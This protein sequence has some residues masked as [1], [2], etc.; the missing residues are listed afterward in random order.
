[1]KTPK[2]RRFERVQLAVSQRPFKRAVLNK[3]FQHFCDTGELPE[4]DDRLAQALLSRAL[5]GGDPNAREMSDL[6][7]LILNVDTG[8]DRGSK[9]KERTVRDHLFDEAMHEVRFAREMARGAIRVLVFLDGDV[10]DPAFGADKGLPTHGTV[11]MH[12]LEMPQRLATPPYVEQG[13]RLFERMDALRARVDYDSPDWWDPIAEALA[14]FWDGGTLPPEGLVADWVFALV[15]YDC[16]W[17]HRRGEDV[18]EM[19]VGLDAVARA[20]GKRREVAVAQVQALARRAC[21]ATNS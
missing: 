15:E 19:L 5:H 4:D 2:R 11:G 3:A 10:C 13:R 14:A 17:R 9:R 21:E 18:P 1:M 8:I 7:K 20:K 12:V 6:E 16:L